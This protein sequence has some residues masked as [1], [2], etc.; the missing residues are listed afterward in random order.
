MVRGYITLSKED[1]VEIESGMNGEKY[2]I[3]HVQWIHWIDNNGS[4][5]HWRPNLWHLKRSAIQM[6]FLSF[7]HSS[8]LILSFSVNKMGTRLALFFHSDEKKWQSFR[9]SMLLPRYLPSWYAAPALWEPFLLW[10]FSGFHFQLPI[11]QIR[12]IPSLINLGLQL[13]QMSPLQNPKR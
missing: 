1:Q 3:P 9:I 2:K 5:N 6:I 4:R 12:R 11:Y 7:K 13:S 8:S 10:T